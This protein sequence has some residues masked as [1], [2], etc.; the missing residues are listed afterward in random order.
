MKGR[1]LRG[2]RGIIAMTRGYLEAVKP[3]VLT[4]GKRENSFYEKSRTLDLPP[5][6]DHDR[7]TIRAYV[8][9]ENEV[10]VKVDVP[11]RE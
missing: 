11:V 8:C 5:Y 10:I 3:P 2:E 9:D 6:E 7:K 4:P 1:V